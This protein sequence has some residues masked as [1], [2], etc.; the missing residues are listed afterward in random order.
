MIERAR[1][2]ILRAR[3]FTESSLILHWLTREFGRVATIAKGAH[4]PKSPFRGKLDLF[5]EADLTF[6]RSRRSELHTLREVAL[7]DAHVVLR[8][9]LAA[10]RAASDAARLIEQSTE[11]GTPLPVV[12][13]L[14]RDFLAALARTP[15]PQHRFAFELKLLN[16]LGLQ[17]DLDRSRL[18]AGVKRIAK[19]LV[20]ADW[21]AVATLKLSEAQVTELRQFLHGFL[22][23]HLGRGSGDRRG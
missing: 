3:P 13:E 17:P 18:T 9:D 23:F 7:A 16:E 1:G 5:Y 11:T 15:P 10:L 4:R 2:L 14:M 12:F 6:V 19:R 20:T 22:V 21:P 8:Q